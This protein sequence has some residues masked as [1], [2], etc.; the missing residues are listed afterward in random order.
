[1]KH[2][3]KL[4]LVSVILLVLG[5]AV[6]A[7]LTGIEWIIGMGL[8]FGGLGLVGLLTIHYST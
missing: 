5:W 6:H 1:M 8:V 2:E 4:M 7:E 3:R